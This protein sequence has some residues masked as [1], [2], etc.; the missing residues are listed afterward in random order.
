MPSI[1]LPELVIVFLIA[2]MIFG[3]GPF[4]RGGSFLR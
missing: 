3:P 1:P 2:L 4:R